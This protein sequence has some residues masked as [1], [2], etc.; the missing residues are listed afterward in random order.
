MY[1]SLLIVSLNSCELMYTTSFFKL[2][3]SSSLL[4]HSDV[5]SLE[6][7]STVRRNRRYFIFSSMSISLCTYS[8]SLIWFCGNRALKSWRWFMI[9][10]VSFKLSSKLT[11]SIK[12]FNL[13]ARANSFTF[14]ILDWYSVSI[15]ISIWNLYMVTILRRYSK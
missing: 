13:M 15:C 11:S 7:K 5:F 12:L 4:E 9:R 2:L 8:V 10:R 3:R 14:V 1:L 6:Y